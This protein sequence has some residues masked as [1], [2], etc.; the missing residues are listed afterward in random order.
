MMRA[1]TALL[2][3]VALLMTGL[4][5]AAPA[6]AAGDDLGPEPTL[7][8][9]YAPIPNCFYASVSGTD[10]FTISSHLLH[11]GEEVS[12]TYKW[13]IGGQG[14]GEFPAVG[15]VTVGDSGAGLKLIGCHGPHSASNAKAKW[16]TPKSGDVTEGHTT[17]HWRAVSATPW[18]TSLGL[19]VSAGG[20]GYTAGD[21]YA[22]LSRGGAIEGTV[23]EQNFT[24][25][26]KDETGVTGAKV[27]VT[28][29]HGFVKT[30][31][32][33]NTGY[34]YV[35]VPRSGAYTATPEIPKSYWKGGKAK[36]PDPR[37]AKVDVPESK[38]VES[39]FTVKSTL[40]LKLKL[41]RTR[42]PADGLSYVTATVTATDA[43][44]PKSGL[45][46]SL[47]P[48]GGGSALQSA[49]DMPVPAT[50]C[51]VTGASVGSRLWPSPSVTKP[52]TDSVSVT[53]DSNGEATF[54]V[55]TGTV[56][57]TFP[58]SVWAEDD[59]GHLIAHDNLNVSADEDIH[60]TPVPSGGEPTVALEN[61]LNKAGNENLANELP[62]YN[63]DIVAALAKA[64]HDGQLGGFVLSPV[65][66]SNS[67]VDVLMSPAGS[68][69]SFDPTTGIIS[70]TTDGQIVA[71]SAS[72]G[73]SF[74]AG[75]FWG[76]VKT[77]Q[78]GMFPTV[79]NW[80][81]NHAPGYAFPNNAPPISLTPG[82]GPLHY[83]GFGYAADCT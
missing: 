22:V 67:G 82:F 38:T 65:Q 25:V 41:D 17:C 35:R 10:T 36:E 69:V 40:R 32:T 7:C 72:N 56:P 42:V 2:G 26:I 52:N 70:P 34:Y 24:G 77:R 61:Y 45:V 33:S 12:G 71:P 63:V 18:S 29:P 31:T 62:T 81:S 46:F 9:A 74:A 51:S 66:T 11:I 21:F 57:G 4:A 83:L 19:A 39:S 28:G 59:A 14:N 13:S 78:A 23:R 27:R 54:R 68:R 44:A 50:I 75:G 53:T 8:N 55:Y 80:L 79:P 58:L 64:I 1:W 30:A 47:R 6:S 37:F 20:G 76:Q 3:A 43:G 60:V 5:G 73:S 16:Q 49:W 48:F 15:A